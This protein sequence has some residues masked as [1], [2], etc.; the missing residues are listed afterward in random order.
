MTTETKKKATRKRTR[1]KAAKKKATPPAP[2]ETPQLEQPAARAPLPVSEPAR[3]SPCPACSS[4][5][6]RG[7]ASNTV[8]KEICGVDSL[9]GRTFVSVTW[10]TV[11]CECGQRYRAK[12]FKWAPA[13]E[14]ARL[15][16]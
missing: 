14:T 7:D 11:T 12:S 2:V 10:R 1:K 15:A 13:E 4:S 6:T 3:P 8:T 9:T 16:D 5:V